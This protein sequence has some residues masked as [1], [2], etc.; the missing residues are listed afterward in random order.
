VSIPN[1][2]ALLKAGASTD[3]KSEELTPLARAVWIGNA[4]AVKVMVEEGA[5]PD[6]PIH[7]PG[8][9]LP[10]NWEERAREIGMNGGTPLM[11]ASARGHAAVAKEL[12]KAGANPEASIVIGNKRISASSIA[13]DSGNT[14]LILSIKR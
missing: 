8:D 3:W 11:L 5:K 12:F 13:N 2:R 6:L 9:N 7:I 14:L 10:M 4:E 1:L